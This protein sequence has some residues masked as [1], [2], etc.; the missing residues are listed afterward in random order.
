M[1]NETG[2][3]SVNREVDKSRRLIERARFRIEVVAGILSRI[4]ME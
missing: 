1:H 4:E 3:G 2:Q